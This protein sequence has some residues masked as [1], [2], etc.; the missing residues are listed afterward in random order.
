MADLAVLFN[1]LT[2]A[3]DVCRDVALTATDERVET[4]LR[5]A[6]V[7]LDNARA[8]LAGVPVEDLTHAVQGR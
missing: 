5:R 7:H 4:E 8:L 1:R 3:G 6:I 2:K